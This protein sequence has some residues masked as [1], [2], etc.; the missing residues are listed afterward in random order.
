M[1][2]E[3]R[4]TLADGR[5]I[6]F[7][8]VDPLPAD[9]GITVEIGPD[10]P[11]AEGPRTTT[12]A[13]PFHGR[14]YA[15]LR[16]VRS[17]CGYGSE[18]P[19]GT[20]IILEFN[21]PL[22]LGAFDPASI[23]VEPALPGLVVGAAGTVIDIRG[24]TAA[25][26]TYEVTVPQGTTDVFGQ[27][28]AADETT[29]VEIGPA[30]PMLLPFPQPFVTLD[31]LAEQQ[32]VG[33]SS[34]N[35]ER[36][37]VQV[38]EVS[39]SDW[40]DYLEYLSEEVY[41]GRDDV[42]RPDWPVLVDTEIPTGN[43]PDRMGETAV[44]LGEA[45]HGGPGH[46][47]V[48]VATTETYRRE[49]EEYWRNRPTLA[50]VQATSIGLDAVN[51]ADE[52]RVWATDLTSGAPLEGVAVEFRGRDATVTTDADG[53]AATDLDRAETIVVATLGDDTALLVPS[54]YGGSWQGFPQNDEA[55]W[56]VIDDRQV[57][58]P[59]ETASV[60]GWVRRLTTSGEGQL[61]LFGGDWRVGFTARDAQ[62]N[63]IA[64][65]TAETTPLGGFDLR[66]DVPAEANL[67]PAWLDLSLLDV[68]ELP[69]SGHTHAFEI[70][71]FRR[72]EFE[73]A[74]R[75]ES[76]GPYVSSRPAT[77]A[78]DATYYAGGPLPAAPVTWQ[79]T[80]GSATYE[81]PGWDEFSFGEWIPWWD[82][83]G[84]AERGGRAV[85]VV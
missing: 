64:S 35:H 25:R 47:V 4:G 10:T 3:I 26:T 59:G 57:Y 22:D 85:D 58:R 74:A 2:R 24:A 75:H 63:E 66:L 20:D 14:T 32:A 68:G 8:P 11:S 16:L 55:R 13:A 42:D 5:W 41:S 62:G 80:T 76:P 70:Q 27:A 30:V 81:P 38:F 53:L 9:S 7:R 33:V 23:R 83:G 21:N 1:L 15:P 31:P 56:Y 48:R 84:F 82:F 49:S 50:W 39:P 29:S 37:H 19:P 6:A 52:L 54:W 73:V 28:L 77:V 51:D 45:L 72:P 60:K 18:C 34:T 69:S 40:R 46:V 71:E 65:G 12:E 44:D 79:V 17:S 43:D 67:G 78:V 61:E 36:L